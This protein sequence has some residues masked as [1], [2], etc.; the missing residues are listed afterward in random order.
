M[1]RNLINNNFRNKK[2]LILGFGKEGQSTYR[3]LRE[4]LPSQQLTI[5]D[6]KMFP[7]N[8]DLIKEDKNLELL[9]GDKYLDSIGLF[10]FI[11]KSPGVSLEGINKDIEKSKITSQ[12]DI[13]INAYS[14]QIIGI[15][16]TKGKST[17]AKLIHHILKRGTDNVVLTGNIGIPPFEVDK[18]INKESFIVQELSSHQLQYV[19][20]SPAT[21]VLLNIYP[22]HLD[23]FLNFNN[24]KE[25]KFNIIRFQKPGDNLIIPKNRSF[26]SSQI[27]DQNGL[28]IFEF[29]IKGKVSN[30]CFIEN[31]NIKYIN[32]GK[33]I[34]ILTTESD[35]PLTGEH[36]LQNIMAAII[37]CILK[38]L[39]VIDIRKALDSFVPLEHRLELVGVYDGITYYN[40]SIS[41]IPESTIYAIKSIDKINTLIIGGYDRGINY[42]I[43][44][45]FLS[46][47]GPENIILTG[48]VGKRIY[49]KMDEIKRKAQQIYFIDEFPEAIELAK[50]ICRKGHTC[51]FSPAAASYDRF[52]NFEE[53]GNLFKKL[54]MQP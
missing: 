5:A 6:K 30:G 52:K 34:N 38:N 24:Y 27:N 25:A 51:L 46:A 40:D 7:E 35:L 12:T 19:S 50:K 2:V 14:N 13:F 53:R 29:S 33:E 36:N 17:T 45:D 22:E 54:V 23:H 32:N 4:I 28:N 9:L 26:L 15:T 48:V 21:A 1:L 37:V 10:D 31:N 42:D 8:I 44:I 49:K 3:L 18:N 11:I 39:D 47:S 20:A 16:G 43:L 41:T